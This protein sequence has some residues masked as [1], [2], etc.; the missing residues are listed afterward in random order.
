MAVD[1][2]DV[3]EAQLL[4]Q[5]AS[6]D[7]AA[8]MLDGPRHRAVD[9][10]AE[11]GGQLLAEVA[12]AGI[13][14]AGGETRQIVAHRARRRRDR[15]VVVVEDDDQAGVQRAGIVHRLVGHAGRH[16]A[17]ADDGDHVAPAA[18]QVAGHRHAEPGRNG[19]RGM[20]RAERIVLA[21]GPF[22]EAR[23]PALLPQRADA[24]AAA[25]E[26]LVRIGLMADVP[27][28]PVVRRVEHVVQRDRQFDHAEPGSEMAAGLRHRVDHL[29]ADF[30]GKPRQVGFGQLAQVRRDADGVEER[31]FGRRFHV[32]CAP[33]IVAGEDIG[34]RSAKV[35]AARGGIAAEAQPSGSGTNSSS[36][37]GTMSKRPV[38]HSSLACSMRS[39]E[40]ETKFHQM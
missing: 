8:R 18:R 7:V 25:G 20:R 37:P 1:R 13:G 30:G 21:L 29:G 16:R 12:D 9:A 40:E 11:I 34:L 24:V 33:R 38:R 15:H 36:S 31:R 10:L 35:N 23:Q 32:G 17:V 3:E 19:G 14:R 26:N 6:G 2:T 5:R 39:F 28:Q 22:R 27:D 4:E